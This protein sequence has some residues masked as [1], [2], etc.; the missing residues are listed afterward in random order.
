MK[1]SILFT[2]IVLSMLLAACSAGTKPSTVVSTDLPPTVASAPTTEPSTAVPTM[3]P[4]KVI[5]T[6]VPTTEEPVASE[7]PSGLPADIAAQLDSYLQSQVYTAGGDPKLAAPGLVLLV[8]TP[9]GRYMNAAGVANLENGTPMKASDILEI[10]S[11]TKSMTIV[12][13]MQLVE[14]GL[15]SLDDPLSKYLPEQAA[16]LP[17]GD[18][19]TI[20][21]MAQHTAGLWDYAD[22]IMADGIT[23]P[24]KLVQGYTPEEIVQ[25]AA[26]KGTPYFTPGEEGK[27]HYSNTGY[28]LLGMIIEKITG[29]KLGDLMQARIFDPLELK[30]AV[31]LNDVPQKGE[32]TTSGYWWQENGEMVDTTNWNGSQGWAAGSVVMTAED[33]AT[34]AKALAAGEFFQNPD[35]LNE[36]LTF[37]QAA[38]FNVGGAYGLGLLDFA[39]DGSVWGHAGQTLGFQS[40]WFVDPENGSVVVGLTN[41]A[42]YDATNLLNVLNIVEGKGAQPISA[43]TLRPIGQYVGTTWTWEQ[44][45]TP[46]DATNIDAAG[47]NILI[48]KDGSVVV[49]SADCGQANGTYTSTGIGNISFDIDDYSLT[50][51]DDSQAE[52]L[53]KYL[54][55]ATSWSFNNGSLLIELP[56]DAGTLVFKNPPLG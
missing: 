52:Q 34:Y 26:E 3:V 44:L 12:L 35:T 51:A 47:L 1:K 39:G 7:T 17:N 29:E 19:I 23:D 25:Y 20:R 41:S 21:Q 22:E 43:L 5:P 11:N 37:N 14:Q 49:N 33:L 45:V 50:C 46:A 40:L 15:I 48:N 18:Q 8:D 42:T 24:A 28:I 6:V 9:E 38:L 55:E 54:N 53:V 13:L 10:G 4:T 2:F 27:W 36:M 30:S 16:M 56:A 31:L 32:I